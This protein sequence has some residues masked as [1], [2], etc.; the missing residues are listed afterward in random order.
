MEH[1]VHKT[2]PFMRLERED[3][4]LTPQTPLV[5]RPQAGSETGEVVEV[6]IS[7]DLRQI[8][9]P[10]LRGSQTPCKVRQVEGN[11]AKV[12]RDDLVSDGSDL[13]GFGVEIQGKHR[14]PSRGHVW[15]MSLS[16]RRKSGER[17]PRLREGTRPIRKN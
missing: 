13:F 4:V 10:V 9:I 16:P 6:G 12:T 14:R 8:S 17:R 11:K 5:V 2:H 15:H 3:W 7:V 1:T